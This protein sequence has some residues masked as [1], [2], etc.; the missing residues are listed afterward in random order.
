MLLSDYS[1]EAGGLRLVPGSH[2]WGQLPA[3]AMEDALAPHPQEQLVTAPAGSLLITNSHVWHG[4]LPNHTARAKVAPHV[5]FTRRDRAQQAYQE[6]TTPLAKQRAMAL[7][8]R[9]LCALGDEDN[10]R[11]MEEEG[12]APSFSGGPPGTTTAG[13]P[14]L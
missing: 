4:G 2:L 14:K 9:W 11:L 8:G 7:L 12:P 1:E 3:A 10:H 6:Q 5:Y 13:R